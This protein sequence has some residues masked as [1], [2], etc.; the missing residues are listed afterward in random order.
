MKDPTIR[1]GRK[2]RGIVSND[3]LLVAIEN[4][5]EKEAHFSFEHGA[6]TM[7]E[8]DHSAQASHSAVHADADEGK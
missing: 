7:D 2:T 3:H 6:L 1:N 8:A 5:P 4:L